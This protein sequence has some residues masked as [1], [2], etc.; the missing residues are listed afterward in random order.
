VTAGPRR[1][2]NVGASSDRLAIQLGSLETTLLVRRHPRARRTSLRISADGEGVIVVIPARKRFE[3]GVAIARQHAEWISD[4]L[5]ALPE[6]VPFA[7]GTV[8]PIHGGPRL[9]RH[10]RE[11]RAGVREEGDMLIVGGSAEGLPRR[12][13]A[14]LRREARR[15]LTE[16][17]DA[18]AERLGRSPA[19][20]SIRDTR[21][22]WGS[23]SSAGA[24]SF[25]WRLILA[26][27]EVLDYVVAHEMAHLAQR[28]HGPEFWR[29]VAQ[30]TK[31]VDAGRA[32]LRRHGRD[33]FRY[34]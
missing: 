34:G 26:P 13:E 12:I 6:R 20:I 8:L 2:K 27:P 31:H 16:R 19:R 21:S 10:I 28:G 14:W 23:C 7:D 17:A 25:S 24:L 3:D 1:S 5:Q 22:R 30:L 33:L 11:E 29:T 15:L 32:W 9:V 18:Q 4:R